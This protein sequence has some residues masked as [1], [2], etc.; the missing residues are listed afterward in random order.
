MS[1]FVFC[2]VVCWFCG[3]GSEAPK[4]TPNGNTPTPKPVQPQPE[5][6]KPRDEAKEATETFDEFARERVKNFNDSVVGH[7][8]TKQMGGKLSS[9]LDGSSE[10]TWKITAVKLRDTDVRRTDSLS[11]PFVGTIE[12]EVAWKLVS[13]KGFPKDFVPASAKEPSRRASVECLRKNGAWELKSRD[14]AVSAL[15]KLPQ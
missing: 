15:T 4:P 6:A 11:A 9:G 7:E 3:C 5:T 1:R 12:V 2:V 8:G 14:D 10:F 13:T